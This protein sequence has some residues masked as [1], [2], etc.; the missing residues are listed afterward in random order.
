MNIGI[1]LYSETG[2]TLAVAQRVADTLQAAGHTA[3]IRQV[4][5]LSRDKADAPVVLKT[6]PTVEGFDLLIFAAPVQA[7]SL[8]RAMTQYLKQLKT[9][10]S[11][12]IGCYV[13][14]G[15]PKKWMGGN[16]AYNTMRS[17]LMSHGAMEP[18]R[19]GHVHWKSSEREEQIAQ[20][21]SATAKFA[22]TAQ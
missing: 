4:T 13:T 7:F 6:A 18:V 16:R 22:A 11:V 20:L 14:Q 15:L 8:C 3:E 10:P 17:L 2:N 9:V 1:I 12:P 19:L 21:V 5:I